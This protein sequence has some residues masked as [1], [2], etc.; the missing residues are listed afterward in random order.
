[1]D[2]LW[3][4][5]IRLGAGTVTLVAMVRLTGRRL[6]LWSRRRWIE[7]PALALY[8]FGFSLAY[9]QLDAGTGALILFGG[10]Q[11]VMFAGAVAARPPLRRWIG[12]AMAVAGLALL[13]GGQAGPL[14]GVACMTASALGW[15]VYSL[16]GRRAGDPIAVTAANFVLAGAGSLLLVPFVVGAGA[17]IPARGVVLAVLSGAFTSGLGYALWY[18]V[19]PRLAAEVAGLAQLTVP[20]IA[21]AS[22]AVLLAE[23]PAGRTLLACAIILGGVTLGLVP[24]R[25]VVA[26][27]R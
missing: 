24:R 17:P 19:L 21:I 12:G 9:R 18:T 27:A 5:V 4:G 13:S 25:R 2:A 23:L 26:H 3:F 22:G 16:S 7:A 1:M 6:P 8:V 11:I 20:V 15:G 10:V 14:L